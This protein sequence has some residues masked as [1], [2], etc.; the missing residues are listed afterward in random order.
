MGLEVGEFANQ[1]VSSE[2]AIEMF[3]PIPQV[4]STFTIAEEQVQPEFGHVT[5]PGQADMY[6]AEIMRI[7]EARGVGFA[8]LVENGVKPSVIGTLNILMREFTVGDEI[9]MATDITEHGKLLEFKQTTK[10]GIRPAGE[11]ITIVEVRDVRNRRPVEIPVWVSEK[12]R[13]DITSPEA[14]VQIEE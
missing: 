5:E 8:T 14:Q 3:G 2:K 13:T 4:V 6:F 10:R 12:L 7:M 1:H 11:R 9:A